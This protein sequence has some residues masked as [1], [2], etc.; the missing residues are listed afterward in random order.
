MDLVW[1]TVGCGLAPGVTKRKFP[2]MSLSEY[3]IEIDP[4]RVE[5]VDAVLQE[6]AWEGWNLLEDVIDK[7]AWIQGIGSDREELERQ[8][9][10]LSAVLQSSTGLG[11]RLGRPEVAALADQDWKDSYKAHFRA[12]HFGPLHW[13]P[14]W[15][16]ATYVVP[17]GEKVLW[18]DPG[19]AFGTGNH[20]TTRLCCE[21]LVLFTAERLKAPR[22][23]GSRV[24]DAGCGSGILALSAALL[25]VEC[26]RG[27]DNDAEAVRISGENA[28]ANGLETRVTFSVGDLLTG[29]AGEKADLVLANIQADIL[30]RFHR[31]LLDAVAPGGWLVLSGILA[32]ELE[33]VR[34]TFATAAPAWQV[35]S[36]E[37]GEWSS[38][39]L[40]SP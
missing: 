37:M 40:V 3:R 29:F 31:E 5:D 8:W 20:E 39:R 19:L 24:I 9:E 22:L 30:M 13:V 4:S 33:T 11:L 2:I 14:E 17:E 12:W 38:L 6:F 27:F 23:R 34:Q 28:R 7:R 18:L 32:R 21:D 10:A 15:E 26:V 1:K 16:K 25:G 36:R 35:T